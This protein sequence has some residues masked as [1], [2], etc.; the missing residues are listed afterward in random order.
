MLWENL[1]SQEFAE[2]VKTSAGVCVIPIGATEKHGLH[3]PVGMDSIMVQEVARLAAEAEPVVVFPTFWFGEVNNLQPKPGAICLSTKLQLN[4]LEEL[5]R[6]IGRNGFKKILFL[7]GHG[8]NP[9]ILQTLSCILREKKLDYVVAGVNAYHTGVKA[10]R[11]AV[12]ENPEAF[13]YLLPEDVQT[14]ESYFDSPKEEGHADFEETLALLGIRPETVDVRRMDQEKGLNTHR[15]DHLQNVGIYASQFW[16]ANHPNHHA[17]TF[18]PGANER[19]GKAML[20]IRVADVAHIFKVFK[21]DTELLKHNEE[22]NNN[23]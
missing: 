4:Y 9:P 17:A 5:C 8:G 10:L 13:P 20:Q 18:H 6:E 14:L 3:L 2:A 7:N 12:R 21:E 11:D 1:K 16:F 22:W 23:W 15:M 19:L